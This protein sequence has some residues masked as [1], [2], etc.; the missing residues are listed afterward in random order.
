MRSYLKGG[1][2]L[3]RLDVGSSM[4]EATM[5]HRNW[6]Y[7]KGIKVLWRMIKA[8]PSTI[9]VCW[10]MISVGVCGAGVCGAC[11]GVRLEL[12]L[13]E[14][15]GVHLVR[16]WVKRQAVGLCVGWSGRDGGTREATH[17]PERRGGRWNDPITSRAS[18]RPLQNVWGSS[19]WRRGGVEGGLVSRPCPVSCSDQAVEHG[20]MGR[21]WCFLVRLCS[22]PCPVIVNLSYVSCVAWT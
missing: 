10:R 21:E 15:V 20:S 12:A 7:P 22:D 17:H 5:N 8:P 18:P 19:R 13:A 11:S 3:L 16:A 9:M 14:W 2:A 6:V 4:R 1:E